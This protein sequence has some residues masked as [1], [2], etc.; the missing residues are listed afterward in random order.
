MAVVTTRLGPAERGRVDRALLMDSV[1]GARHRAFHAQSWPELRWKLRNT[2]GTAVAVV[3]PAAGRGDELDRV[4]DLMARHPAVPVVVY[5]AFSPT[6]QEQLL[7]LGRAGI[8]ALITPGVNDD[9]RG[10]AVA[11]AAAIHSAGSWMSELLAAHIVPELLPLVTP[12][13]ARRGKS[14]LADT[15]RALRLHPDQTRTLER[16]LRRMGLPSPVALTTWGRV[17]AAASL[18]DDHA[19]TVQN[20]A[21]ATGFGAEPGMQR[22]FRRLLGMTAGQA[23]ACGATRTALTAFLQILPETALLPAAPGDA[24]GYSAVVAGQ[25]RPPR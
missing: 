5:S 8:A 3:D 20:V 16:R 13:I 22:T 11:L 9:P 4:L 19:R 2:A 23:R 18:L 1:S 7:H 21:R 12:L 24:D 15:A 10:I 14:G 17:L 6:Q 25:F